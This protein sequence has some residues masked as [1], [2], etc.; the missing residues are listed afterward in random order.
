MSF[1]LSVHNK[2]NEKWWVDGIETFKRCYSSS[3]YDLLHDLRTF[4][5]LAAPILDRRKAPV[6]N[7]ALNGE[8]ND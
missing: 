4:L 1:S 3:S 7:N 8:W 6:L 5:T 2:W